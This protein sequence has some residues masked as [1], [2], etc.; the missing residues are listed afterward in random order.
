MYKRQLVGIVY[1]LYDWMLIPVRII[2][3]ILLVL[4]GVGV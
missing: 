2:L 4:T 1:F 3:K